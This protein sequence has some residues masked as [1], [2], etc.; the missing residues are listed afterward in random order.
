[1]VLYYEKPRQIKPL[2]EGSLKEL[3][4]ILLDI[5]VIVFFVCMFKKCAER[6]KL[7][8]AV[9]SIVSVVSCVVSI[10]VAVVTADF[11][12]LNFFKQAIV[13]QVDTLVQ[14]SNEVDAS[15]NAVERIMTGMPS[16]VNNGSRLY[17]T[18]VGENLNKINRVLSGDLTNATGEIVDIIARP[19]IDGIL[20]ALFFAVMLTACYYLF[21][22]FYPTVEAYFYTPDRAAVSPVVS[23]V[24][25][26]GKIMVVFLIALSLIELVDPILPDCYF[27]R[28]SSYNWSFLFKLFCKDNL[29]MLFLG[30]G[31][32]PIFG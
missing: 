8:N 3:L 25:G 22:A 5:A 2:C 1:M 26:A 24:L 15:I 31:V 12:Y 11:C 30:D 32:F 14:T 16:I 29:I 28:S 18:T 9:E 23:M 17:K 4:G 27:T 20:R 13:K 19:V 21:K 7:Q 10:P 6:S